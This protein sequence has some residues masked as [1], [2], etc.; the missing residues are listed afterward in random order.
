MQERFDTHVR[1]ALGFLDNE[2]VSAGLSLFL[3]LYASL[4]A[5]KLPEKVARLF[6]NT[7]VKMV[8]FFLIGYTGRK[9]PTV[10]A[11]A[12]V[13]LMVT[14]QTLNR[15]ETDKMMEKAINGGSSA[16]AEAAA[17]VAIETAV[18]EPF[19]ANDATVADATK[20]DHAPANC[21]EAEDAKTRHQ[22]VSADMS[23]YQVKEFEQVDGWNG[24]WDPASPS[25][26]YAGVS[27]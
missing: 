27:E 24:D 22:T 15:Y 21:E 11:I 6:D 8:V 19:A 13:A 1:S 7:F 9:N 20:E 10:A 14:L 16:V 3:I 5:P 4:A 26:E 18:I 25:P 2:Y 12:A 17:N 23:L